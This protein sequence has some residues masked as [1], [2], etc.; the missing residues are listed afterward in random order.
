MSAS[1]SRSGR[2]GGRRRALGGRAQ[3]QPPGK[4]RSGHREQAEGHDRL[5]PALERVRDPQREGGG[6]ALALE[7]GE[8]LARALVAQRRVDL[9]AALDDALE[10][11][12]DLGVDL[13]H[14]AWAV[15]EPHHHLRH[16]GVRLV[17]QLPGQQ[18]VED[19]A[20]GKDVGLHPR[21]LALHLLGRHVVGRA[22]DRAGRGHA[23]AVGGARDAEVHEVGR[24]RPRRDHDVLRL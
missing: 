22:H 5:P 7:I 8:H 16:R 17:G 11:L 12:R 18:L 10:V 6:D 4:G 13:A 2:R 24:A 20:E 23:G 9:E 15:R 19:H 3:R 21:P 14:R 1:P